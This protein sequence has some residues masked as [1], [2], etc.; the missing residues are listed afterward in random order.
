[1]NQVQSLLLPSI[2]T[3]KKKLHQAILT[4]Y[5]CLILVPASLFYSFLYSYLGAPNGS[6]A[7][8]IVA[9]QFVFSLVLLKTGAVHLAASSTI[10]G[11]FWI[12]IYLL[13]TNAGVFAVNVPWLLVVCAI[14]V[15][16]CGLKEG[17]AWG[18]AIVLSVV[19]IY[20]QQVSGNLPEPE[21]NPNGLEEARTILFVG[22]ILANLV[23]VGLMESQRVSSNKNSEALLVKAEA[24][25]LEA[26][27]KEKIMSE[28]I[29]NAERNAHLLAAATE[30][31]SAIS[32]SIKDN[33][34]TLHNRASQQVNASESTNHILNTVSSNVQ[35]CSTKVIEVNGIVQT[36]KESA[37]SGQKAIQKTIESMT[38]IQSNNEEINRAAAKISGIAEQTNLLALNAAIEAARAGEQGR[39]F[40]V[41]ADQIRTL[42]T[43]SN[44]TAK[45]IQDSLTHATSSID[46]GALVVENAG[47]QL[48]K[49]LQAVEEIY[50][51]FSEV[52]MYM[53][54]SDSGL[55]E[56]TESVRDLTQLAIENQESTKVVELNSAHIVETTKSLSD[57]AVGLQEAVTLK[58]E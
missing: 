37:S 47:A 36:T 18:L 24:S 34:S 26:E 49:I 1:M 5:F 45:E 56:I 14:A 31:L 27:S 33:T 51:H 53:Q 21:L 42:A 39:G 11:M 4:L 29:D 44:I 8:L 12:Q 28:L 32:L 30:E 55:V 57:M 6:T 54:Q 40:A 19:A 48:F 15:F 46:E 20:F 25:R 7:V 41:V 2:L 13:Y 10:F 23:M 17:A 35:L 43:Q 22:A 38:K 3:D 52:K 9:A 58:N 50:Q 16:L